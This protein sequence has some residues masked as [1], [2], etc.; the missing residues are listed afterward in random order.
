[1]KKRKACAGYYT[2]GLRTLK[3]S[4]IQKKTTICVEETLVDETIPE[5]RRR[6]N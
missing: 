1:M 2:K 3:K 4:R 6:R 5:D